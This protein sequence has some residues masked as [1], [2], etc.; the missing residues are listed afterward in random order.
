VLLP[1]RNELRLRIGPL[2]SGAEVWSGGLFPRLAGEASFADRTGEPI[3]ALLDALDRGELA[4]P[5]N[6]SICAEDEY[7][8]YATLP[9]LG[10]WKEA[11]AAA[12]DYFADMLGE[13]DML[14]DTTLAPCGTRWIAAA[15]DAAQV[16]RWRDTLER[17]NIELRSVRPAL[18]EDL[19]ALRPRVELVDGL[20]V[21]LRS[22]GASMISL[23][24]N[25]VCDIVWERFDVADSTTLNE[26]IDSAMLDLCCA[27]GT[28]ASVP[29]CLVPQ[30][31]D[32][33][34]VLLELAQRRGWQFSDGLLRQAA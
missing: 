10:S 16:D 31:A 34:P 27:D 3:E 18:L 26:R 25:A 11:H 19:W 7:V 5:R 1:L 12:C 6:A 32:G 15:I 29:V 30:N 20:L 33:L 4:L 17:R 14:I 23:R 2:N 28:A 21:L 9:G 24:S 22:E 13:D 8:Y